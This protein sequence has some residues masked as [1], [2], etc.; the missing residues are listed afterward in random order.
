MSNSKGDWRA[1]R[2]GDQWQ[3]ISTLPDGS[4]M[5]VARVEVARLGF[6][7]PIDAAD[8]K[9][10]AASKVMRAALQK[11]LAESGCDGDLCMHDWHDAARKALA[12]ARGES[13]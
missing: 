9:L 12:M 10:M 6:S 5:A 8:A 13:C 2:V 11:A 7:S 4:E 1:E 3:I